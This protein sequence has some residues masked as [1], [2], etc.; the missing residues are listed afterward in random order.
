MLFKLISFIHYFSFKAHLPYGRRTQ[1]ATGAQPTGEGHQCLRPHARLRTKHL[2]TVLSPGLEPHSPHNPQPPQAQPQG[3]GGSTSPLH[4]HGLDAVLQHAH[5]TAPAPGP[6]AAPVTP[7][8]LTCRGNQAELYTQL[9]PPHLCVTASSARCDSRC[10]A[11]SSI[12][13]HRPM[14]HQQALTVG[15]RAAQLPQHR[16]H[17]CSSD[18]S[19]SRGAESGG[20]VS[21][22][23]TPPRPYEDV[24][25]LGAAL[26]AAA[27]HSI[28]T[29][30]RANCFPVTGRTSP[31]SQPHS[32]HHRGG[33]G[34]GDLRWDIMGP[35]KTEPAPP[36]PGAFFI[37]GG[38]A[39]RSTVSIWH[40]GAVAL[41][42]GPH[43]TTGCRLLGRGARGRPTPGVRSPPPRPAPPAAV[44]PAPRRR[45]GT[46]GAAG[47]SNWGKTR[48]IRLGNESPCGYRRNRTGPGT[49]PAP[50]S[51]RG[52]PAAHGSPRALGA[53]RHGGPGP[54]P[55]PGPTPGPGRT[56]LFRSLW[57][58]P[59]GLQS[60][61]AREAARN[62]ARRSAPPAAAP[63]PVPAAPASRCGPSTQTAPQPSPPLAGGIKAR[64]RQWAT[65]DGAAGTPLPVGAANG[66]GGVC[67]I[68]PAP[69]ETAYGRR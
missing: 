57:A 17:S 47:R 52:T 53:P 3:G 2:H 4:F 13:T 42:L 38:S 33:C 51:T 54:R 35:F 18:G 11:L 44:R 36:G 19:T 56:R 39:G 49:R 67:V 27:Q 6:P 28:A 9:L 59:A 41:S 50:S 55:R 8:P 45:L 20:K 30:A 60:L 23:R 7:N 32:H 62:P 48:G 66:S 63:L 37:S 68:A 31:M 26:P 12:S 61:H 46:G 29:A 64:L 43:R 69:R 15:H 24:E 1:T 40:S 25:P 22:R 34:T 16:A 21:H 14:K 5:P 65:R 10:E 58:S